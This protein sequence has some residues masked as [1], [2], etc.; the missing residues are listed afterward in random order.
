M[1]DEGIAVSFGCSFPL[2]TFNLGIRNHQNNLSSSMQAKEREI[3]LS[4]MGL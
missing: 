2:W 1:E 3:F 4:V